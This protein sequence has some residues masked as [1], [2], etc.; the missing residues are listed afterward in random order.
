MATG[1]GSGPASGPDI[2]P[3]VGF[4]GLRALRYSGTHTASGGVWARSRR[5]C[6][7]PTRSSP[8]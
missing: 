3:N 7:S 5:T 8:S 4:T 2:K 6:S 1:V